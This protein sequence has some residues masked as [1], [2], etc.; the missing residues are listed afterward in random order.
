MD[1]EAQQVQDARRRRLVILQLCAKTL[2]IAKYFV[3]RVV[4]CAQ[5][6][7]QSATGHLPL[8]CAA[9]RPL[10]YH[11]VSE[12]SRQPAM[13][14]KQRKAPKKVT[15][16]IPGRP[17]LPQTPVDDCIDKQLALPLSRSVGS[18][19]LQASSA[20]AHEEIHQASVTD[21][22]DLTA[23]SDQEEQ[24]YMRA[25]DVEIE[26]HPQQSKNESSCESQICWPCFMANL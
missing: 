23:D 5:K 13:A 11:S 8:P 25:S 12:P 3:S 21:K 17:A 16:T 2:S 4:R 14:K 9:V 15:I 10:P 19:Q 20:K 1:L 22:I 18:P 6:G 26:E 7:N 24:G